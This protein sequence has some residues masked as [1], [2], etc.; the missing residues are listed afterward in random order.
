MPVS[1][2]QSDGIFF[3]YLDGAI[4]IPS[5]AELK[6]VILQGLASGQKLSFDLQ[7]AIELDITA[8]QLLCATER[9]AGIQA[10]EAAVSGDVPDNL[11]AAAVNA[12]L[13]TFPMG[14]K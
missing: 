7:D 1:I 2:K 10:V 11:L 14:S 4:T 8:L 13:K 12:G 9:E 6:L 3:I 5:A